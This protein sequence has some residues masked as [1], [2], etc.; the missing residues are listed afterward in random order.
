MLRSIP[1]AR[2]ATRIANVAHSADFAS[3]ADWDDS[4]GC[5][6]TASS[7]NAAAGAG[8]TTL[9]CARVDNTCFAAR[10]YIREL[11]GV[12]RR[13]AYDQS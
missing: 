13:N 1:L 9:V 4:A 2:S 8:V 10:V 3:C 7:V 11:D 12:A 6:T 5:V